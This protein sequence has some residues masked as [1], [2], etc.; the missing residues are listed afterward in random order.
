MSK[1]NLYIN[2][3]CIWEGNDYHVALQEY[4]DEVNANPD[5]VIDLYEVDEYGNLHC[6][7]GIN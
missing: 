4:T 7:E 2:G 5:D 1:Y 6:M 3:E